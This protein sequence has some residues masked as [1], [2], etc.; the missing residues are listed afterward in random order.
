MLPDGFYATS[1]GPGIYRLIWLKT[2][3]GDL[4]EVDK[5]MFGK[6][7]VYYKKERAKWQAFGFLLDNG[8]LQIHRKFQLTWTPEQLAAIRSAVMAIQEKPE[9]AKKLY[10]EVKTQARQARSV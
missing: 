3:V 6:R 10:S 7:L 2:V 9:A 1:C 5:G 4:G 8:T